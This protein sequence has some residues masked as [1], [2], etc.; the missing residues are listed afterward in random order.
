M[1]DST[2]PMVTMP[3]DAPRIRRPGDPIPPPRVRLRG[4]FGAPPSLEGV[5]RPGSKKRPVGA[6]GWNW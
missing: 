1:T 6:G 4:Y 2:P 3:D 5:A